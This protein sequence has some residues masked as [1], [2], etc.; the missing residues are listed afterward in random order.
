MITRET[1]LAAF[2]KRLADD[3]LAQR[4][5]TPLLEQTLPPRWQNPAAHRMTIG[6]CPPGANAR[7]ART[8]QHWHFP[9]PG[10]STASPLAVGGSREPCAMTQNQALTVADDAIVSAPSAVGDIMPASVRDHLVAA[11]NW[12]WQRRLGKIDEPDL[13]GTPDKAQIGHTAS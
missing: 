1:V 6:P 12:C 4:S 8:S 10:E 3:P 9:S 7:R 5:G 13:V 2:K 11:S